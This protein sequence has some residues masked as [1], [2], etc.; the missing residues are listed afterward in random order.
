MPISIPPFTDVPAPNDQIAS[1]WA[2]HLT[3]FAVDLI[4]SGPVAPTNP[5]AELWYDTSDSG[6]SLPN[7]PRGN[8]Y[9]ASVIVPQSI[10]TAL[11]WQD[12]TNL[13]VVWNPVVGRRYRIVGK[14]LLQKKTAAGDV[15][16]ALWGGGAQLDGACITLPINAYGTVQVGYVFTAVSAASITHNL[17]VY[18][19]TNGVDLAVSNQGYTSY[20]EIDD[21][22]SA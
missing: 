15:F 10:T 18:V 6:I 7:T 1:P 5:E 19:N 20:L 2:Q 16:F 12:L 3:Q 9:R 17:R 21:I 14:G 11:A 4:S 8:L 22:G 13:Y